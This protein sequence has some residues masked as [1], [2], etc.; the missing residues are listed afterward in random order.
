[1]PPCIKKSVTL[2]QNYHHYA[3]SKKIYYSTSHKRATKLVEISEDFSEKSKIQKSKIYYRLLL[4]LVPIDNF[5]LPKIICH[6]NFGIE[7]AFTHSK[8]YLY[9]LAR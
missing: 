6:R 3:N 9:Y 2:G 8:Y 1:M 4:G 7:V 5:S